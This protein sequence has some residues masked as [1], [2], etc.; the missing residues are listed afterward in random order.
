MTIDDLPRLLEV[1]DG[2]HEIRPAT[3]QLHVEGRLRPQ[4]EL[5]ND[6]LRPSV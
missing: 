6:P 1:F 3:D 5:H 2:A 4:A